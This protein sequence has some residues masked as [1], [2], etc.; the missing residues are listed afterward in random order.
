MLLPL[1]FLRRKSSV[2]PYFKV[3]YKKINV[4]A[5]LPPVRTE[6]S[7]CVTA[8]ASGLCV[9]QNFF[10]IWISFKIFRQLWISWL[11]TSKTLLFKISC[12]C[13]LL[14]TEKTLMSVVG[15]I[16]DWYTIMITVFIQIL[17]FLGIYI[18]FFF[19]L[20][21]QMTLEPAVPLPLFLN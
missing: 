13:L 20:Q 10:R 15:R 17:F 14:N 3:K 7:S 2:N 11:D 1:K 9:F 12:K 5:H 4:T 16:P 19:T 6:H 18:Y 8:G 21:F